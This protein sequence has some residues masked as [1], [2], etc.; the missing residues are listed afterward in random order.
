LEI[1]ESSHF[2]RFSEGGAV[3]ITPSGKSSSRA[4][5]KGQE[6]FEHYHFAEMPDFLS[7]RTNED[8]GV[9]REIHPC[10][11]EALDIKKLN[12]FQRQKRNM[13]R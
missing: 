3:E 5:Q 11:R 2:S 7:S 10:Y 1:A 13:A 4:Q 9:V 6:E 8:F 12:I